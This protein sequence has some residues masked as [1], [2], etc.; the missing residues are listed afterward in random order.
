MLVGSKNPD[1]GLEMNWIE[2]IKVSIAK[3]GRVT[4]EKQITAI[5]SELKNGEKAQAVRLYRNLLDGDLSIHL[6][7]KGKTAEL[8]GSKTGNCLTH[9]LKECGLVSH[10]VWVEKDA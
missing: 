5:I 3:D 7:W 9:L 2:V 1:Q 4:M 6:C 10:S 8:R